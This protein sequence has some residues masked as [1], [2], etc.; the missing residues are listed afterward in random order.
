MLVIR[1]KNCGKQLEGHPTKMRSC[2]CENY[3]SIR[4]TSISG[5]DLSLVEIVKNTDDKKTPTFSKEDL[6]YQEAR[7]QRK[8]RKLDFE[9]R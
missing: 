3:T 1:C 7:R 8:V 2:G 4:G 6:A 5:K 9:V